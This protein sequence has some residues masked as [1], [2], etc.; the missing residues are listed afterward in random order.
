[1]ELD[2]I[3]KFNAIVAALK[4]GEGPAVTALTEAGELKKLQMEGVPRF[5]NLNFFSLDNK[6]V[7]R[8]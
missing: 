3:E 4:D 6:P 2:S 8:E 5:G 7:N 1:M